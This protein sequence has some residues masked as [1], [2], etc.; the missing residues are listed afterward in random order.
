MWFLL[1]V[2]MIKDTVFL[3]S[4]LP[5]FLAS[6]PGFLFLLSSIKFTLHKCFVSRTPGVYYQRRF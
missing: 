2:L 3:T 6:P 1:M 5:S 4:F